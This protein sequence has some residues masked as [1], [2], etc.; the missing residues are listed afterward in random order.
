MASGIV[1][2]RLP[3]NLTGKGWTSLLEE[4]LCAAPSPT[5]AAPDSD[6]DGESTDG[7]HLPDNGHAAARALEEMKRKRRHYTL[8]SKERLLPGLF[9]AVFC[10]TSCTHLVR[11]LSSARVPAGLMN[12]RIGNKGGV[13]TSIDFAGKRLLFISVHLAAHASRY[14]ERVENLKR[15]FLNLREGE[16]DDFCPDPSARAGPEV[17]KTS[18]RWDQV[19]LMGDMNFRLDISRKHADWLLK[20]KDFQTA[21]QFDQLRRTMGASDVQRLGQRLTTRRGPWIHP[22]DLFGGKDRLSSYVQVRRPEAQEG[23]SEAPAPPSR[24]ERTTCP[25]AR[26]RRRHPCLPNRYPDLAY[27]RPSIADEHHA[28]CTGLSPR[29]PRISP[30]LDQQDKFD[31]LCC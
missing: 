20:T 11:G 23:E 12:G 22:L 28:R 29:R 6:S 30:H 15:I 5:H 26:E 14:Q 16:I 10:A 27:R 31:R 19:F 2:G 9:L 4:W 3:R 8:M 18:E 17:L 13:A 7:G 1:N 21:L 24:H 25:F